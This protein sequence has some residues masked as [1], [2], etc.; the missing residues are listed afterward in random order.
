MV[1][2][3]HHLSLSYLHRV[4]GRQSGGE[5]VAAWIRSQR[6][7][8]AR[9]DLEDPALR[10]TPVHAVAARWGIPRAS[11]FSRSFRAAYGVS[12]HE[13]RTR[14][15]KGAGGGTGAPARVAARRAV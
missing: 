12:P 9:Q 5:T 7:E 14:A 11:D 1:A 15:M 10:T 6:L 4:F 8:R 3:A 2:A 13:H